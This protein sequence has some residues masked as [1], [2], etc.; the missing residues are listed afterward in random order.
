MEIFF[1]G[2]ISKSHT[3]KIIYSSFHRVHLDEYM[4]LH[5]FCRPTTRFWINLLEG[6]IFLSNFY[7]SNNCYKVVFME[8]YIFLYNWPF[9]PF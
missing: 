3:F 6:H 9:H 8:N 4:I 1:T 2:Q 7:G 5:V